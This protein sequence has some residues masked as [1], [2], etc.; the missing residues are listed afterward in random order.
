MNPF[1]YLIQIILVLSPILAAVIPQEPRNTTSLI[2]HLFQYPDEASLFKTTF[3]EKTDATL[4]T[5]ELLKANVLQSLGIP[6]SFFNLID[7]EPIFLPFNTKGLFLFQM[8]DSVYINKQKLEILM[9]FDVDGRYRLK[10][11]QLLLPNSLLVKYGIS[12]QDQFKSKGLFRESKEPLTV[13]IPLLVLFFEEDTSTAKDASKLFFDMFTKSWISSQDPVNLMHSIF[14]SVNHKTVSSA[15]LKIHESNQQLVIIPAFRNDSGTEFNYNG[16]FTPVLRKRDA[17]S[18]M[19]F[20]IQVDNSKPLVN[21]NHCTN[22][23]ECFKEEAYVVIPATS[24]EKIDGMFGAPEAPR[25]PQYSQII[26][27]D[28]VHINDDFLKASLK[29]RSDMEYSKGCSPVSWSNFFR[30]TLFGKPRRFC[31]ES[32]N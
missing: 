31:S 11:L 18:P 2:G 19:E 1:K 23:T 25:N 10:D 9:P 32:L 14:C 24:F 15:C 17:I 5:R 21:K 13:D 6:G 20:K 4:L 29:K 12:P 16:F 26:F 28:L 3:S 22:I 30:Y 7:S 27:P 8:H